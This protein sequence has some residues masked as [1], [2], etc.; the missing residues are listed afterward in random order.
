MAMSELHGPGNMQGIGNFYRATFFVSLIL[1]VLLPLAILKSDIWLEYRQRHLDGNTAAV[2]EE[3]AMLCRA[4]AGDSNEVA[5]LDAQVTDIA[6]SEQIFTED[7]DPGSLWRPDSRWSE[8]GKAHILELWDRRESLTNRLGQS[9]ALL[10]EKT[11]DLARLR[12]RKDEN[13]YLRERIQVHR[14]FL[15]GVLLAGV[16]G[17]VLSTLLW[18]GLVQ[19]RVNAVLAR[20]ASRS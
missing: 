5:A 3:L 16:F 1:L 10:W 9:R 20:W 4:V 13:S 7:S 14:I 18:G 6:R 11:A 12:A 2:E 8:M 19:V 17:V 15:Y